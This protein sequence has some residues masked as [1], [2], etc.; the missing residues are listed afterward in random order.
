MTRSGS[1]TFQPSANLPPEIEQLR[2]KDI[3][4]D[5]NSAADQALKAAANLAAAASAGAR[6]ESMAHASQQDHQEVEGREIQQDHAQYA[7]TYGMMLGIRVTVSQC[8][9]SPCFFIHR[10]ICRLDGTQRHRPRPA[11]YQQESVSHSRG[12]R[13]DDT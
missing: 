5:E 7:L 12:T 2:C 8:Y 1:V 11:L 4:P 6:R 13:A 9:Q 10:F 3:E